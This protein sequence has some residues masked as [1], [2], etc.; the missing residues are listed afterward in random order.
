MQNPPTIQGAGIGLRSKHYREVLD[1]KIPH[2]DA[3]MAEKPA[4]AWVEVLTDN[5]FGQGGQPHYYLRKVRE[6]YPLTFHGVG[7]SLGSCDAADRRYLTR[8]KQLV[9]EYQPAWISEHLAWVSTQQRFLHELLPVPYTAEAVQLLSD[10]IQIV[11]EY[12][13]RP[14]LIENP[15]A[16]LAFT[17]DEMTEWEFLSQVVK[18]TGCSLLLDVNNIYVSAQNNGFDTNAYLSGLPAHAVQEIHLAG[19]S[20]LGPLL[21]DSHG[22]RVHPPVWDLYRETIARFGQVPTLIEWDNDIP[23]LSVLLD[24]AA[25]AQ[26][27]L[28]ACQQEAA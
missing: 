17:L 3:L 7:L 5:Y 1:L 12:L 6:A 20:H 4:I 27:V 26:A 13:G 19:Y 25:K 21:F 8:L 14:I 18:N 28:D 16:Y 11:Q 22:Q 23:E 15:S 9:D 24:E 10:K 2:F